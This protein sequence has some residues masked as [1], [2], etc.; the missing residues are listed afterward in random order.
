MPKDQELI[1]VFCTV[2]NSAA[3]KETP[4]PS[5]VFSDLGHSARFAGYNPSDRAGNLDVV[6][7]E[8]ASAT[9]PPLGQ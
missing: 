3:L 4:H 9:P 7:L 5:A 2:E 6:R 1:L 8:G